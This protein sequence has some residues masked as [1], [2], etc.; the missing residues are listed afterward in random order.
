[1]MLATYGPEQGSNG[2]YVWY[3][4]FYDLD[5]QCG[6]NNSGSVYWDYDVNAQDEG[7]FSGA[8]S[9]LWDNFY[10]CFLDDIKKF[11]R[12]MRVNDRTAM[13]SISILVLLLDLLVILIRVVQHLLVPICSIARKVTAHLTVQ[14]SSVIV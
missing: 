6:I 3:P 14:H 4:I 11:Y 12:L 8:G 7:I 9:V 10:A 13:L 1:M 5:T 2:N